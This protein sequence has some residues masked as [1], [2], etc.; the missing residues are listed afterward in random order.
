MTHSTDFHDDFSDPV[1]LYNRVPERVRVVTIMPDS[2]W[3]SEPTIYQ[4][5][6]ESTGEVS[7]EPS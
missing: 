5:E 1:E 2:T 7:Q 4:D 6:K 3:L